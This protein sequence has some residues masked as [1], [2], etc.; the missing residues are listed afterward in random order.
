MKT[1]NLDEIAR[2]VADGLREGFCSDEPLLL[3]ELLG[4]L[5]DG[6]A[7]S[8]EQLATRLDTSADEVRAS[9]RRLPSVEL[10]DNGNVVASGLTLSPTPH[11]FQ[12]RGRELFTWCALDTLLFPVMLKETA[13]VE[14]PCP[15]TG[16]AVKL[17]VTAER[18]E[19]VEPTKAVVSIVI[20][21]ASEACCDVRGAFCNEVHFFSSRDA[22]STWLEEHEGGVILSVDNAHQMARILAEQLFK[23]KP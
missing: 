19:D 12:V 18:V 14:S 21:D 2:A 3:P 1:R 13:Q 8:P 23:S 6:R 20:P 7:V 22:A 4:L 16:V 11:R 9:L 15:V 5:A 10:D 17:S